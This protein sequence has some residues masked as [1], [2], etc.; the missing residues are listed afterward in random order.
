LVRGDRCLE[1]G[2]T[3]PKAVAVVG[4]LHL[5]DPPLFPFCFFFYLFERVFVAPTLCFVP[6]LVVVLVVAI[7]I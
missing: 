2:G 4:H 7:L 1:R 3:S 6:R 5:V